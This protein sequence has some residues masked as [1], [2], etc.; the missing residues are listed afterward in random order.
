MACNGTALLYFTLKTKRAYRNGIKMD[1]IGIIYEG[2]TRINVSQDFVQSCVLM[3]G[4]SRLG[5][6]HRNDSYV[7]N[8]SR[9]LYRVAQRSRAMGL[10]MK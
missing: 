4:V 10:C 6:Q 8:T 3:L 1:F 7:V 2:V 5:S 9:V